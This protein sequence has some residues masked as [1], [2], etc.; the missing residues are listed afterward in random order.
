MMGF[1]KILQQALSI[2]GLFQQTARDKSL[3]ADGVR[4]VKT[5]TQDERE[6][7]RKAAAEHRHKHRNDSDADILNRL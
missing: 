6:K 5:E 2:F 7:I 1:L 3:K 4:Q